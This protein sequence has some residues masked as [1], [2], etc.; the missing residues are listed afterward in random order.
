MNFGEDD[1]TDSLYPEE[2]IASLAE[3]VC[4]AVQGNEDSDHEMEP[5]M[6]EFPTKDALKALGIVST[7]LDESDPH[8]KIALTVISWKQSEF[9]GKKA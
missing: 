5:M 6:P 7:F 2:S 3:D 4:N 8:D 9:R 1:C